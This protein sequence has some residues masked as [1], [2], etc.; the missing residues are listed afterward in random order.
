MKVTRIFPPASLGPGVTCALATTVPSELFNSKS[1]AVT[2]DG[3]FIASG[4]FTLK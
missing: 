2:S 3:N 4:S 1:L